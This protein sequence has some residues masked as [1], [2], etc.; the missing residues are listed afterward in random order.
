MVKGVEV[1]FCEE[2]LGELGL[3][4]LEKRGLGVGGKLSLQ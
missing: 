2:G 4:R 3:F 1:K